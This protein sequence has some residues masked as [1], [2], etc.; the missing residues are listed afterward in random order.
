MEQ[1]KTI[2]MSIVLVIASASILV[3]VVA[4]DSFTAVLRILSSGTIKTEVR[5]N[6]GSVEDIQAA[7]NKAIATGAVNVIIPEGNWTFAAHGS[8]RVNITVPARGLNIFGAGINRTVLAMPVDDSAPNTVMFNVEGTSGGRIRISGIT[9]KGRPNIETSPTGDTGIEIQVCKDFRIDHCSFYYMGDCGIAVGDAEY[10]YG[11][12]GGD[13]NLIS[14]GVVDHCYFYDIYKPQCT[15]AG[16]GYG[17]GVSV[18]V[19]YHYL[20]SYNIYWNPDQIWSDLFGKYNR[21]VYIED[22][23]FSRCRHAAQANWA[24]AYV[25]RYS[26]IEDTRPYEVSTTGHPVREN[27][28][29]MLACE[30]YNVTIRKTAQAP[31]NFVGPLVEGGSALIYNNT[32]INLEVGIELGSC[33]DKNGTPYHPKGHTREV[34]IWNNRYINCWTQIN[35]H[36]NEPEGCPAPIL[37]TE[38][39]LSDPT[40]NGHSYTPYPY[41]HPLTLIETPH[42]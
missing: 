32:F 23:Y 26:T 37:G 8:F 1:M 38:Y 29:G 22:C 12:Y 25:L 35:T 31:N 10:Q 13:L 15:D 11:H 40:V 36:S 4:S 16:R 28:F 5:A 42:T 39:F 3:S 9:F 30:I 14:Q 6:S 17:Y 19:A 24:G 2:H 27:V 34:Y 20:W 33:E 18:M 21:N 7:I 41:P